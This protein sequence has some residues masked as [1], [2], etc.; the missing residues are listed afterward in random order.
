MLVVTGKDTDNRF[1][2]ISMQKTGSSYVSVGRSG[3][4][5]G[6]ALKLRAAAVMNITET[7]KDCDKIT[8]GALNSIDIGY[9]VEG[10]TYTAKP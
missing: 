2:I 10:T 5:S 4:V 1:T 7:K 9:Y 3:H 6:S 8:P